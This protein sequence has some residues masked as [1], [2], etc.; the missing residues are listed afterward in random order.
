MVDLFCGA[1]GLSSGFT[2]AGWTIL[3]AIDHFQPAVA[4]YRSNLGD[5]VVEAEIDEGTILPKS[6]VIAGGPPCQGFSSAGLRRTGDHRNT[7]VSVYAKLIVQHRPMAFVFENV[8]GFLTGDGGHH[9]LELLQPLIEAGYQIHLRKIN[10]ANYGVPQLRK[11]V[12]AIGGLGW[13]PGFPSPINTAFGAPGAHLAGIGLPLSPT[14]SEALA[15][16]PDPSESAPGFPQGHFTIPIKDEDALRVRS[17][18]PGQTMR[19]LPDEMH[20]DS[21]RRRANRRVMDGTPCDKRGGAPAGIR[22]L[23]ADE[24]CKAITGGA[25]SEFVHPSQDR[26]LTLRECAR[27]QTFPDSF[28]FTGKQVDQA[29]LIGNAVPPCLAE[30]IGHHLAKGIRNAKPVMGKGALLSFIP[31]LSSGMSPALK[32]VVDKVL[33]SCSSQLYGEQVLNWD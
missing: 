26:Y 23:L 24:P 30:V 7:L 25:R 19:D 27:I 9:V 3:K 20:H 33:T 4:T 21:F 22:R 32:Q 15:G 31:T 29:L 28:E 5:H 13:D 1:G 12:L 6:T 14:V 17:L 10:A 11:R 8:E 2:K 16:L 18:G